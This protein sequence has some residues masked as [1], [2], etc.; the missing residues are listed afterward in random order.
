[1][2]QMTTSSVTRRPLRRAE[3]TTRCKPK[4]P[5]K[6]PRRVQRRPVAAPALLAS[7]AGPETSRPPPGPPGPPLEVQVMISNFPHEI[8]EDTTFLF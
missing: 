4:A 2:S 6:G 3:T 7:A 1:M 5:R 8:E